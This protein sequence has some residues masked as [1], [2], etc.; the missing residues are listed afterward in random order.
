MVPAWRSHWASG[1]C[2]IFKSA[3]YLRAPTAIR[4]A[5]G[6]RKGLNPLVELEEHPF[7][8]ASSALSSPTEPSSS[9]QSALIDVLPSLAAREAT[10]RLST[11]RAESGP[12]T[13][14]AFLHRYAQSERNQ[15]AIQVAGYQFASKRGNWRRACP[16]GCR[17]HSP[18]FG[19]LPIR[20]LGA[21]LPRPKG[22][23]SSLAR[24]ALRLNSQNK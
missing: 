23:S 16:K 13:V 1:R 9:N 4:S 15:Q 12:R 19:R 17:W 7:A 22:H 11:Q 2:E 21:T 8:L 20:N 24:P 18:L 5:P 6:C 14:Q 3:C 10:A